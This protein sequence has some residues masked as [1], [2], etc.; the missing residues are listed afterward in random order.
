MKKNFIFILLFALCISQIYSQEK[1]YFSIQADANYYYYFIDDYKNNFNYGFSLVGSK[2]FNKFK[3]N[4]GINYSTKSFFFERNLL[5][6]EYN[7]KYLNYNLVVNYKLLSNKN[8]LC[9]FL[10][11]MKFNQIIDYTRKFHYENGYISKIKLRPDNYLG[12]SFTS[13]FNF[14]TFINKNLIINFSPFIDFKI[15]QDQL[16]ESPI[17]DP[18][19]I[20]LYSSNNVIKDKVSLGFTVGIEYLFKKSQ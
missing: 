16:A 4:I 17:L 18:M 5:K 9:D 7:L 8:F 6:L 1:N 11:G 12:I 10:L 14:S 19:P 13:G 20:P 2:Y 15:K 3:I